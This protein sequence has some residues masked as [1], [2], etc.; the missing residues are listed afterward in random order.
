VGKSLSTVSPAAALN[1]PYRGRHLAPN[2]GVHMRLMLGSLTYIYGN[3]CQHW[4]LGFA[5]T[6]AALQQLSW[7]SW[8]Q[9]GWKAW[10]YIQRWAVGTCLR[11]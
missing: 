6:V 1:E 7:N 9:L 2:T 8:Q 10:Q 11:S 5:V 3:V 4:C